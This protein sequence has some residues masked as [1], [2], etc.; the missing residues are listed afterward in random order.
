MS[1]FRDRMV[2]VRNNPGLMRDVV[3][4]ALETELDNSDMDVPDPSNPFVFLMENAVMTASMVLSEQEVLQRQQYPSMAITQ[5]ELYLHMAD[6]DY[7]GRFAT[8]AQTTFEYYLSRDEI[9]SRAVAVPDSRMKKLVIPRL[10]RF[11]VADTSFTMQYPVE[12]RVMSH[13]GLQVV[14]NT[15]SL[16]PVQTLA[17]NMVDWDVINIDNNPIVRLK[18]P[19]K[20]FAI[21]SFRETVNA[22]SGFTSEF[23][24]EDQFYVARVYMSDDGDN[25]EE[26][27]TTHTDQVYDPTEPTAVLRVDNQNLRVTIPIVY[28]TQGRISDEIRIDIY[29]T[30]GP[31]EMDL[32][33]YTPSQYSVVH[34]D[35]DDDSTYVAPLN[36]FGQRQALNP[37]LVTG[38]SDAMGFTDLRQQVIT[39]TLGTSQIPITG[40]QLTNELDTRGYRLVTNIDNITNRQFLASRELPV[41]ENE[42][43]SSAIGCLMAQLQVRMNALVGSEHVRDNGDRI[44]L[45]PSLLYQYQDG[46]LSVVDDATITDLVDRDPDSLVREVN[47]QRYLYTPLHYVFDTSRDNFDVRP[48]YLDDPSIHTKVFVDANDSTN[49]QMTVEDYTIQ[50]VDEGFEI[51]V[52]ISGSERI[53]EMEDERVYVQMGYRPEGESSYASQNGE[54]ID[55]NDGERTYRFTLATDYDINDTDRLHT[56]NFSM[57]DDNQTDFYIDLEAELD[58]SFIVERETRDYEVSELDSLVQT[59]LLPE[60]FQVVGREQLQ[61]TLGRPLNA[62][63]RRNRTLVTER[64]YQRYS[65]DVPYVYEQTMYKR[66]E[67]GHIILSTNEDGELEYEIEHEKGD[68]VL[69]RNGEQR[70]RH[71]AGDIKRDSDGNPIQVSDRKLQREVTLFLVDGIYYFVD[72]GDAVDYRSTIPQNLVDWVDD[73]VAQ[74]QERLLE[75]SELYLYPRATFGDTTAN[76]REG[77]ES[78]VALNQ[79]MYVDYY[80]TET[81]HGNAQLRAA[82]TVTTREIVNEL[83]GRQTVVISDIMARL[84]ENAGE[85]V[86]GVDVGGLGGSDNNFNVLS[87]TDEASRLSLG[88]RLVV[89]S[90]QRIAAEDDIDVNFLRHRTD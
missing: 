3:L 24:F 9:I 12:L 42:D 22:A 44:T 85:D 46:V 72:D 77:L 1:E 11:R 61:A 84:R 23:G 14:Y 5:E 76:V 18:L 68:P 6:H 55:S 57:F 19:V 82:L 15:D 25:W 43:V 36:S 58:I 50:R 26:I 74:L 75:Q 35:T 90:N 48:Y 67:D 27:R 38:G 89:R 78:T 30:K 64:D 79:S 40:A 62:L 81:A 33:S 21:D 83:L 63:W 65:V 53:R 73:D 47:S 4:N 71:R 31:I 13:G 66:D 49:L 60:T 51:T 16:S 10:T 17:S 32:G 56:T 29:T 20:Q 69:D 45:L 88:Q 86:L 52:T 7:I 70:Y 59:H 8:P 41:P 80:L 39:N 2:E 54:L 37:N 34:D 87:L 28:F